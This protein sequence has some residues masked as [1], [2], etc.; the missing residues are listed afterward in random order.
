MRERERWK[1]IIFCIEFQCIECIQCQI[2]IHNIF[3]FHASINHACSIVYFTSFPLPHQYWSTIFH[4][5]P[6]QQMYNYE[7]TFVRVTMCPFVFYI[8]LLLLYFIAQIRCVLCVSFSYSYRIYSYSV[9]NIYFD[10]H[11]NRSIKMVQ[12]CS[13][14]HRQ[15]KNNTRWI[16]FGSS[17]DFEFDSNYF[18]KLISNVYCEC[19]W[20]CFSDSLFNLMYWCRINV[21]M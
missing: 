13:F 11:E 1:A 4:N 8:F 17:G 5:T 10:T 9:S 15:K 7:C 6:S 18:I 20:I 12:N 2:G 16:Y 19:A 21:Y 3:V 14:T